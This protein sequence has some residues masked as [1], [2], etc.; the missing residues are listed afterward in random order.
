MPKRFYYQ[1][2]LAAVVVGVAA[3]SHSAHA[4]T[5]SQQWWSP[6]SYTFTVPAGVT[7]ISVD[8]QGAGGGGGGSTSG[9]NTWPE[10]GGGG[11]GGAGSRALGTF[12]VSPGQ[13]LTVFVG[14]GGAGGLGGDQMNYPVG[15]SGSSGGASGVTGL[16]SAP[17]GAGGGPGVADDAALQPLETGGDLSYVYG[18]NFCFQTFLNQGYYYFTGV[19]DTNTWVLVY[20]VCITLT[21]TRYAPEAYTAAVA[22]AGGVSGGIRGTAPAFAMGRSYGGAGGSSSFGGGGGG[23][24]FSNGQNAGNGGTGG[25]GGGGGSS[26][27]NPNDQW[28]ASGS[29]GSGYVKITYDTPISCG[30]TTIGNCSLPTTP[31]GSTAGSCAAGYSGSCSYL[32]TNGTW[33]QQANSCVLMV[34]DLTAGSTGVSG[35][36]VGQSTGFSSTVT[37]SGSGTAL[38]FPNIFQISNGTLTTTIARIN[39]GTV[40][41]LAVGASTNI[42]GSYTFSSA[43]SYNVRACANTNTSGGTVISESSTSNNCGAWNPITVSNPIPTATLSANPT[44]VDVGQT[45]TLTW[46][47]T[48]A[49]SCTG[50]GFTTGGRTSGSASTGALNTPGT[51]NYQVVCS[52]QGGSSDPAFASVEVVAPSATISASPDRVSSGGSSTLSWSANNVNSCTVTGPTGTLASGASDAD[53]NFSTGSPRSAAITTQSTFTITC[54]TRTSPVSDSVIVNITPGFQEF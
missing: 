32:C 7:L 11:G 34:P 42:S 4:V 10:G 37:N 24:G 30:A 35:G 13:A 21:D 3:F 15:Q 31:S 6:G 44:S 48:N 23:G 12:S 33:G 46:N 45:S 28:S 18:Y 25:G 16:L 1:I 49:T 27:R 43:G 20:P 38:N 2:V 9:T 40:S 36:I 54:Q 19:W 50:T 39:T 26:G 17:G 52:G 41:S 22:G 29:G 47:S 51:Q 5:Q 8:A 14:A 53:R